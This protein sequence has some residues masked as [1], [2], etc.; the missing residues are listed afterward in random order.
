M[1]KIIFFCFF[2][3]LSLVAPGLV[4]AADSP[5]DQGS[6]AMD[7]EFS[8]GTSGGELYEDALGNRSTLLII[9]YGI[10]YFVI[11]HLSL[12]LTFELAYTE[13]G[14][15]SLS[16]LGAGPGITYYFGQVKADQSAKGKVY[17][18][19]GGGFVYL[20]QVATVSGVPSAANGYAI[21][22]GCGIR[23]MITESVAF[24]TTGIYQYDH[25]KFEDETVANGNTVR[26]RAGFS[27][28][29]Y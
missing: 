13:Q 11:P 16:I 19:L 2:V 24:G 21:L 1:K 8:F 27:F 17:P 9:D 4:V 26:L 25:Y 5:I 15:A 14:D 6:I 20:R 22:A 12:G 18:Y 29:I 10:E 23:Y 28:F 3:A 7:G